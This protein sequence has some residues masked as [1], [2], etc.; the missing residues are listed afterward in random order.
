MN[1]AAWSKV[2]ISLLDEGKADHIVNIK[3][4]WES[5]LRPRRY[6]SKV[7]CVGITRVWV[8]ARRKPVWKVRDENEIEKASNKYLPDAV[9]TAL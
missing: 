8:Q 4:Q 2:T 3:L 5:R 7:E 1:N 9:L 6:V